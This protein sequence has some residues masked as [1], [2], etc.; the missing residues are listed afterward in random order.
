MP[1]FSSRLV[2][3]HNRC[4]KPWSVQSVLTYTVNRQQREIL[5]WDKNKKLLIKETKRTGGER[6]MGVI[7][8]RDQFHRLKRVLYPLL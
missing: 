2:S 5:H 6:V 7:P 1:G 3:M 4:R 8:P